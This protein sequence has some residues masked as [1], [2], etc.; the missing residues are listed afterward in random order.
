MPDTQ[1]RSTD[2]FA[3]HWAAAYVCCL[4]LLLSTFVADKE[5]YFGLL[6]WLAWFFPTTIT[7]GMAMLIASVWRPA[8]LFTG[9]ALIIISLVSFCALVIS[10]GSMIYLIITDQLLFFLL[11]ILPPA[12]FFFLMSGILSSMENRRWN[13]S[14]IILGWTLTT[15]VLAKVGELVRISGQKWLED[16]K[17]RRRKK[18]L[19]AARQKVSRKQIQTIFQD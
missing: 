1:K 15:I 6:A 8:R 4:G 5:T 11:C 2:F 12:P 3:F 9:M 17:M 18:E 14:V 10:T 13:I 16:L 7:C 19:R